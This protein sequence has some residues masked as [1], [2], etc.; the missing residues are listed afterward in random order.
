V[1][2]WQIAWA[3]LN[4][5]EFAL[6]LGELVIDA[7]AGQRD[8][9]GHGKWFRTTLHR[10]LLPMLTVV[11]I[12]HVCIYALERLKEYGELPEILAHPAVEI[13]LE[14]LVSIMYWSVA[15][16]WE[17]AVFRLIFVF[18]VATG[19][20]Y[21]L[22]WVGVVRPVGVTIFYG[23]L[24]SLTWWAAVELWLAYL[25]ADPEPESDLSDSYPPQSEDGYPPVPVIRLDFGEMLH[26]PLLG[27][28]TAVSY[29]FGVASIGALVGDY[30]R[31]SKQTAAIVAGAALVVGLSYLSWRWIQK[32]WAE[33]LGQYDSFPDDDSDNPQS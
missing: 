24:L 33:T 8:S 14:W 5:S 15:R 16:L 9:S 2:G 26:R 11:V 25:K 27:F 20:L 22:K 12:N 23:A 17:W 30:F 1:S 10:V 31:F 29:V 21:M 18:P 19:I 13:F 6:A 4:D 32:K 3:T 28:F 7:H